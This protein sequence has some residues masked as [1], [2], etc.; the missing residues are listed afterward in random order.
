MAAKEGRL[1]DNLLRFWKFD[2]YMYACGRYY[3]IVGTSP[4]DGLHQTVL[5]VLTVAKD[6]LEK[7]VEENKEDE[8]DIN[9]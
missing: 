5:K 1:K 6:I 4:Q 7:F 8:I 3:E 9:E 2:N